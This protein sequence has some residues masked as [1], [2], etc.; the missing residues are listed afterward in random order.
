MRNYVIFTVRVVLLG[1]LKLKGH[2]G[3]DMQL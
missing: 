2:V 3:L 1:W